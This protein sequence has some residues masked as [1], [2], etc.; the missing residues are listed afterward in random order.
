[1]KTIQKKSIAAG[2]MSRS[3]RIAASIENDILNGRLAPGCCL[4]SVRELAENYGVSKNVVC[5]AM[6]VL[7]QKNLII[8]LPRKGFIVK[9]KAQQEGMI[10]VL[11]FAMDREPGK[12]AFVREM[13]RLPQTPGTDAR[14]N[15]TIRLA[16]SQSE[17]SNA[18]LEEELLRLEKFG[19]PDC[20]IIIP[21]GFTRREMEMCLKLPYPVI[22]LGEFDDRGSYPDLK[23]RQVYPESDTSAFVAEYAAKK[24]YRSMVK[25]IPEFA[26]DAQYVMES[27]RNLRTAAERAGLAY[28]ELLI[29][30][31][32]QK[33]ADLLMPY[34][35]E[36]EKS[37]I[38]AA[39]LLYSS[40][41][42]FPKM[43]FPHPELLNHFANPGTGVPWI[44][45]DYTPLFEQLVKE[46]RN[47]RKTLTKSVIRKVQVRC[48]GIDSVPPGI[49]II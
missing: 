39:D 8:R 7:E 46:I 42:A 36:R 28:S 45:L 24:G 30:G 10:D 41:M 44:R 13:L 21:I 23:Y 20:V 26:C 17:H 34:I 12:S 18:R 3:G 38:Q 22:F 35:L 49:E 4:K 27:N 29:P 25:V 14:I 16:C 32:N 48:I 5:C 33:E 2:T 47:C 15:F 40:W 6:D 1:M 11:L 9:A 37:R 19:Y 31:R 43:N